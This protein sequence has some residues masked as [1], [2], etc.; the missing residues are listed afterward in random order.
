MNIVKIVIIGILVFIL[1]GVVAYVVESIIF[2][3]KGT[4]GRYESLFEYFKKIDQKNGNIAAAVWAVIWVLLLIL[5]ALVIY[6]AY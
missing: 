6:L 4:I 3:N 1:T 5:T 2:R